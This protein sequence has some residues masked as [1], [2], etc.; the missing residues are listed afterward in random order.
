MLQSKTAKCQSAGDPWPHIWLP[1]KQHRREW[2]TQGTSKALERGSSA[3][4]HNIWRWQ[5]LKLCFLYLAVSPQGRFCKSRGQPGANTN[6]P[7]SAAKWLQVWPFHPVRTFADEVCCGLLTSVRWEAFSRG[8]ERPPNAT[9]SSGP[10]DPVV[11][12][13]ELTG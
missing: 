9:Y 12:L 7:L 2:E 8:R 3:V 4:I 10:P 11:I 5:S 1:E 6:P 13:Q